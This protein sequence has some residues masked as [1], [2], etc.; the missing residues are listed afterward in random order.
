MDPLI[1]IIQHCHHRRQKPLRQRKTV[2]T[3]AMLSEGYPHQYTVYCAHKCP[4]LL[5]DLELAEISFMPIGSAPEHDSGPRVFRE[6]RFLRRQGM[7]DWRVRRWNASWGIQIYTGIPSGLADAQ[8]HDIDFKYEAL[9]AAP[10]AVFACIEALANAVVNPLL[11]VSKSGGLRFSCRVQDYLHSNTEEERLYIYKHTP[12]AENPDNREVYLEIFG[13]KGYSR[14]DARY[15]ILFGDL[16]NPPVISKEVLFAPVDALR[17]VL[18]EAVPKATEQ[19]KFVLPSLPSL[20]SRDLDLAKEALLKRGFSFV[21]QENGVYHWIRYGGEV[22]NT[23]ILLWESDGT[24]WIRTSTPD[25]DVPLAAAPIADVW[26]DTGIVPPLMVLTLSISDKMLAVREGKL[27]PLAIKRPA[28]VLHKP[29]ATEKTYETFEKNPVQIQRTFNGGARI[30]GFI[31]EAGSGRSYDIESDLLDSGTICLSVPTVKLAGEAE[32]HFQERNVPSVISWK[33]RMYR[34]EAVKEIPVDVRMATPFQHGNVCEDPERCDALEEK[35]G[36]P[37]ESICPQCPVY[38]MC[39]ERGY[40]SQPSTL[41]RAKAQILPMRE[42]FFDPQYAELADVILKQKNGTAERIC[43]VDN[44]VRHNLFLKCSVSRDILEE[45]RMNW[46]GDALGNF[47]QNLLNALEIKGKSHDTAVKRIRAAVQAFEW[48][49]EEIIRQMSQVNVMGRVV[50]RGFIDTETGEELARFI[51]EFDGGASAYIPCDDNARG[52]FM[53]K[54]LPFLALHSFIPDEEM[55]ISMTIADAIRLRILDPGTVQSIQ[56][57]PTVCPDPTWTFWHQMKRFFAHYTRDADAPIRWDREALTF[58]VPPVLHSSIKRLVLRSTTLS[59]RHLHRAFPDDNIE[60]HRIQPT[61]WL[62]GNQVF[63][64][65]T[66][67]YTHETI[68]DY[69]TAWSRIGLSK[70]GERFFA[71]IR[72]EIERESNVKHVIIADWSILRKLMQIIE[73]ENVCFKTYSGEKMGVNTDSEEAEVIWM[74]G[75]PERAIGTIWEH[76]QA[77]FGN[78]EKSLCYD[79]EIQPYHYKDERVQSVHQAAL[80]E[81]VTEMFGLA[82]LNCRTKKKVMLLAG[83]E[84]PEITDRPETHLFDWEDFEIAGGLDKLPEVIATRQRFETE[85]ANLTAESGRDKVQQVL[86]CSRVHANRILRDLRGG[87]LRPATFREQ[88]LSLLADGEKRSVEVVAAI[89]GN[90]KAINHELVR[91]ANVGEIVKVR[92]GV[93]ALPKT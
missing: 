78:D 25:A 39:Q 9:C 18:H 56:A 92:W 23:D 34:W 29:E 11:T 66:G 8:W 83:L 59:K 5:N 76:S 17:A 67:V 36:N 7:Q 19:R 84:L 52:I 20:G 71:G 88:I 48:Q 33:P 28:P 13:E 86:G 54:E 24:V 51:I 31:V 15:E 37:N 53:E 21:R 90:P 72:A 6:D 40:L 74:V 63:Q 58:K 50:A 89:D 62:S 77:L 43:I 4:V 60:V 93:Y 47:A 45:W 46:K 82:Q 57:F 87:K 61:P 22:N 1:D 26:T 81:V 35:G 55:R 44:L 41:Q 38:T 2:A 32:Q 73:T 91:L 70:I 42:M 79:R 85:K 10:D 68:L 80:V 49:K 69:G 30:L 65:R 16:L 12:T 27:S 3:P 64:L 14:W 75:V